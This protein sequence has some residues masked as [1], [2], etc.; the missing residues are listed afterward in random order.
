MTFFY[1]VLLIAEC[2]DGDLRL[3]G[4]TEA[5]EGRLE[6]CHNGQ[7]GTICDDGWDNGDARV[8]CRQLGFP[9][10]GAVALQRAPY[11]QGTGP[12]WLDN[13]R[14]NANTHTRLTDC[15]GNAIG[16]HNCDHSE[17]AGLICPSKSIGE[18]D[19]LSLLNSD[20]SM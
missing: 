12:I 17:D 11:G 15:P 7:W 9:E 10:Y 4:G 14:C 18:K 5:Y 2:A 8:A 16:V 13:L 1:I 6:F 20:C 19:A 3:V